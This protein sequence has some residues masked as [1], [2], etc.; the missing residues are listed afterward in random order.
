G[1]AGISRA[2]AG[3]T[4]TGIIASFVAQTCAVVEA[5]SLEDMFEAV[6]SALYVAGLAA[7]IAAQ[8]FSD[9]LMTPYQAVKCLKQAI[10]QILA[11]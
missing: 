4:L 6:A 7:E 5:P 9:R 10:D 1:N 11:S 3:D 8:K 2:G